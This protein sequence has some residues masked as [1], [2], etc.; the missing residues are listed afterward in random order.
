M[1]SSEQGQVTNLNIVRFLRSGYYRIRAYDT[2]NSSLYGY[3]NEIS[4]ST[5]NNGTTYGRR[6]DL[7]SND[8]TLNT[9]QWTNLFVI[10]RDSNGN[11]DTAYSNRMN[12]RVYR[13]MYTS[14]SWTDITSSSLDNNS[15]AIYASY[16]TMPYS[17]YGDI[18]IS[19]FIKFYD[20]NYDYKVV[21]EDN[22][23][24][25]GMRG[26]IIFYLRNA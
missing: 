10:A 17:E 19:S 3:S 18:D 23:N 4:V 8:T 12:F 2:S 24:P 21:V 20:S 6:F 11:K 7:T 1:G 22:N 25:S 9:H 15:Y 16:Y 5:N 26:E 13:R 14:D